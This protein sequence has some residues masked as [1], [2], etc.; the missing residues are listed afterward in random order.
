MES[1]PLAKR[2]LVS[3]RMATHA[4]WV[5]A[6]LSGFTK[7]CNVTFDPQT[8]EAAAR[9]NNPE[10]IGTQIRFILQGQTSPEIRTQPYPTYYVFTN[11]ELTD[12]ITQ[13]PMPELN[14]ANFPYPFGAVPCDHGPY[15]ITPQGRCGDAILPADNSARVPPSLYTVP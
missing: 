13:A 6:S 5:N 14:F 7:W 12:T 1:R 4:A 10:S 11:G 15:G 3:P 2:P 8:D 9:K